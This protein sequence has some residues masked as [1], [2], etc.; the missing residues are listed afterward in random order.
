MSLLSG[1]TGLLKIGSN[2]L[3]GGAGDNIN[4]SG[5]SNTSANQTTN[6]A[7]KTTQQQQQ[8]SQLFSDGFLKLLETISADTLGSSAQS[9][10]AVRDQIGKVQKADLGKAEIP[11][12]MNAYIDGI[13]RQGTSRVT[14]QLESDVNQTE[15]AIGGSSSGNSMSALLAQKLRGNAASD[16][17]GIT[18][19]ATSTGA[20]IKSGLQQQRA[21]ELASAST[22]LAGL[23]TSVDS[24][25]ANLL[26]ALRGGEQWQE[27]ATLDVTNSNVNQVGTTTGATTEN[28]NQAFNWA[29]GFGNIF[30]GLGSD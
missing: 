7:Q 3:G 14:N 23:G 20:Q 2:F 10:S 26:Q 18:A 30:T 12:D 8:S 21:E 1:L 6:T 13:V 27:T 29:K 28:K 5:T 16:I 24:S 11:F 4:I 15:S 25:L 17:A 19:N 9:Q 22:Q